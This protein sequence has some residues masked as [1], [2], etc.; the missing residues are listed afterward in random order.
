MVWKML[1]KWYI[2][3]V[4]ELSIVYDSDMEYEDKDEELLQLLPDF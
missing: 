2:N 4:G 1:H 3:K